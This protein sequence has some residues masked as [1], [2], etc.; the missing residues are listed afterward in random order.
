MYPLFLGKNLINDKV[1][2]EYTSLEVKNMKT[3]SKKTKA[4]VLTFLIGC[5][6]SSFALAETKKTYVT[7]E[8]ENFIKNY[9]KSALNGELKEEQTPAPSKPEEDSVEMI[10]ENYVPQITVTPTQ[11]VK[12]KNKSAEQYISLLRQLE[13]EIQ[14]IKDEKTKALNQLE[15]NNKLEVKAAIQEI[16]KSATQGF[17]EKDADF[18]ARKKALKEQAMKTLNQK[19]EQEKQK[20]SLSYDQMT[21]NRTI[22]KDTL[23]KE[24][25]QIYFSEPADVVIGEFFRETAQSTLQY[26][27]VEIS[28]ANLKLNGYKS[29]LEIEKADET[30]A[31]YINENKN[32]FTA[33]VIYKVDVKNNYK[34]NLVAAEVIDKNG[35]KVLKRF[36]DFTYKVEPAKTVQKENT[37]KTAKKSKKRERYVNSLCNEL[38]VACK[39]NFSTD[40]N[41]IFLDLQYLPFCLN[42]GHYALKLGGGI[43]FNDEHEITAL[44]KNGL[45]FKKISLDIGTGV[46]F[47]DFDFDFKNAG[48]VVSAELDWHIKNSLGINVAYTPA[49]LR[50]KDNTLQAEWKH[51]VL[52]GI[53]FTGL[54]F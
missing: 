40:F 29:R 51:T 23:E 8:E 34:L 20:I 10:T 47:H 32:N 42:K 43:S 49:E 2:Y 33:R 3:L 24:L 54:Y 26:F 38:I 46:V 45:S 12:I 22:E 4:T 25:N 52:I 9:F 48:Y 50:V 41:D 27:P 31:L 15:A 44:V 53:S 13:K 16:E 30:K 37:K 7:T 21:Q 1:R 28:N 17:V 35:D 36:E 11:D 39:N 6:C 18:N 14:N 5:L 19:L